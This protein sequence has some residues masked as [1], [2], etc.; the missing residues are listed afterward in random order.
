[1]YGNLKE[2]A[3]MEKKLSRKRSSPTGWTG[4]TGWT[5]AVFAVFLLVALGHPGSARDRTID[6]PGLV[7]YVERE[8]GQPIRGANVTIREGWDI[9]WENMGSAERHA[10]TDQEGKVVFGHDDLIGFVIFINQGGGVR[11]FQGPGS[12]M[13]HGRFEFRIKVEVQSSGLAP[14]SESF[15][16]QDDVQ[17]R[18]VTLSRFSYTEQPPSIERFPHDVYV[19]LYGNHARGEKVAEELRQA[20]A[21]RGYGPNNEGRRDAIVYESEREAAEWLRD[22]IPSLSDFR[23]VREHGTDNRNYPVVRVYVYW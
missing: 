17:Y 10:T 4:W 5:T 9:P 21:L 1:V 6:N 20:D 8:S 15:S 22:N 11:R 7:I 12:R 16:F 14:H 2:K 18:N 3:Y 13:D 19:S 23:L